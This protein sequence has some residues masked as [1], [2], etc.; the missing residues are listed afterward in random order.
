MSDIIEC[1]KC[2]GTKEEL[3]T[4]SKFKKCTLCKGEGTI[5]ADIAM[6]FVL[7]INPEINYDDEFF[8]Y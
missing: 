3:L 2:L 7:S 6:D 8:D 1:P 5:H 4:R